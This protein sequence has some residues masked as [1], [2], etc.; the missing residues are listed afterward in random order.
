MFKKSS[1]NLIV[2]SGLAMAL[3][4]LSASYAAQTTTQSLTDVRQEAQ[5]WTSYALNP[6]LRVNTLKASVKDGKVT[7]TGKVQEDVSKE[8]A[9]EIAL[10]VEGIKEVDNQIVVLSELNDQDDKS[11]NTY[12]DGVEDATITATV[13]SKLLWSKYTA[14]LKTTVVTKAGR[15]TLSGTADSAEAKDLAGRLAMNTR[16]VVSVS[17]GLI[18]SAP[19]SE[20]KAT[21]S[22]AAAATEKAMSDS[23]ITTKVKSTLLYS[24]NV[25]GTDVHVTTSK[26]VVSLK[27]A[28]SSGAER[29]LAIELA[30]NVLGVTSVDAKALTF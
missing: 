12:A 26:G 30:Q 1:K 8:L 11:V 6:Y 24:S 18:V 5:I 10:G 29:A 28:V 14:G 13:K 19:T 16:G 2:A 7:L 15:V 9:K 23:W 25:S 20:M 4:S 3:T 21:V 17:N 22:K 27:G